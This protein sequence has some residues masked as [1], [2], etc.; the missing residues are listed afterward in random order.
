MRT[1]P[2]GTEVYI[3][4]GE[5]DA[6]IYVY[7]DRSFLVMHVSVNPYGANP[8]LQLTEELTDYIADSF[9]YEEL[10]K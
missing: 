5:N 4:Q 9:N 1:V 3:A 7:L 10:G 6:Y 8:G 2:D